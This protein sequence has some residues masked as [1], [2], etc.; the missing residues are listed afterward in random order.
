MDT[1]NH[2]DMTDK[3][4]LLRKVSLFANL[5]QRDLDVV[6]Q[7]SELRRFLKGETIFR[8]GNRGEGLYVIREGEVHVTRQRAENEIMNLAHFLPGES[9]G[10]LDIL[11]DRPL[12]A[13][14]TAETDAVLLVFP[15]RGLRFQDVL[16]QHPE[17]SARILH[18]LL[19]F[20]AGRIRTTN[21][22]L[23][24]KSNWIEELKNQLYKDKLTALYNRTYLDE[25]FPKRI[26]DYGP[27]TS[28][29][30]IKPDNFKIINDSCGHEAGDAALKLIASSIRSQL[31]DRDIMVRYRGDEFALIA[32]GA[33][34]DRALE[35]AEQVRQL[36]KKISFEQITGGMPITV[37]AS[38]GVA[39]YP[40]HTA[41]P[42]ELVS[43]CF[44]RMFRAREN[45]G[46]RVDG[47][48]S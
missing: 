38:V 37:T 26:A 4:D 46:D 22:H 44:A 1:M 32:P 3:L 2:T 34:L 13:T 10:E 20:I 17:I 14:A 6:A 28:I 41:D 5:E 35:L 33:G 7:N 48:A 25:E 18:E 43:A 16:I 9:F 42:R 45:G 30:M 19:A 11:E 8:E 40:H 12:T 23:S 27:E 29:V 21:R 24:E 39:V 31:D 36:M 15:P 47:D